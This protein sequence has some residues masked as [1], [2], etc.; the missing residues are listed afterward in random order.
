LKGEDIARFTKK[1][2][3]KIFGWNKGK[4]AELKNRKVNKNFK[5]G[6]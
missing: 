2:F 4:L 5:V 3:N 1:Y 6:G